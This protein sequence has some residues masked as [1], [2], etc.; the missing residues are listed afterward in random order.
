MPC[1]LSRDRDE[2]LELANREL[3]IYLGVPTYVDVFVRAGLLPDHAAAEHG[4]T[5][6]LVDALVPWGDAGTLA[7]RLQ[8]WIDAGADELIVSPF[9]CGRDPGANLDDLLEVL[10]ELNRS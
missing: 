9:G 5:A 2:V 4:W 3:A 7:E 10:G 8:G 6:E 1:V